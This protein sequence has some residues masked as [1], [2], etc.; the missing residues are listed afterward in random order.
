MGISC[1]CRRRS[2]VVRAFARLKIPV[3]EKRLFRAP[4]VTFLVDFSKIDSRRDYFAP[5]ESHFESLENLLEKTRAASHETA[6]S[7]LIRGGYQGY[8]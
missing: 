2:Q 1:R 4:G 5:S 6:P 8:I 7:F 3:T